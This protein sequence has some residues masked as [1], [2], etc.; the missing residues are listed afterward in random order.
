MQQIINFVIRNKA[1]L[2]F[3]LLFAVSLGLTIQTHHYHKS[4]FISS[5]N[6]LTGGTYSVFSSISQYFDLKSENK[7]LVEENQRLREQLLNAPSEQG[8]RATV[9]LDTVYE[10]IPA[11]VFKNS[12]SG[13]YNFIT[14]NKGSRDS[15]RP[16]FGVITDKGIVGIV[17]QSNS[18]YSRVIS[19]LNKNS[20][21]NAQ[22]KSSNHFG[23]LVWDGGSP[24]TVQLVDV[25]KFAGVQINDTVITGGQSAIFPKGIGIGTV[26]DIKSDIGGDTYQLQIALFND[27]T[28][29]GF[30]YVINNKDALMVREI[31][32]EKD[33]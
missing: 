6:R 14:I 28:D 5:A 8:S 32:E 20:R 18:K 24:N 31:E 12:Y 21:I 33:E 9:T 4:Q 15:I 11:E 22:L 27:M 1:F 25:S 3:L 17:D 16:D 29:L 7:R 13:N 2:L 23:S 26:K 30:V 10:V 19:I